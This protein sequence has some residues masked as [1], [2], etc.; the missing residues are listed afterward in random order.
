MDS[1]ISPMIIRCYVHYVTD[2]VFEEI[3]DFSTKL[4]RELTEYNVSSCLQVQSHMKHV[5]IFTIPNLLYDKACLS[6]Q[7]PPSDFF[8]IFI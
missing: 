1:L 4:I 7:T 8:K 6:G 5:V 2:S 3:N